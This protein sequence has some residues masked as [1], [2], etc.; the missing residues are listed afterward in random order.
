MRIKEKLVGGEVKRRHGS[1][2]TLIELLVVIA[3]IAILASMLLPALN[4]ARA[5]AKQ[6]SCANNQKQIG[7]YMQF[8]LD[9]YK[10]FFPKH[11]FA[12]APH[13]W[14]Q[15]LAYIYMGYGQFWAMKDIGKTFKCESVIE[16]LAGWENNDWVHTKDLSYGYNYTHLGYDCRLSLVKKPS[17][18]VTITDLEVRPS[19][20]YIIYPPLVKPMI[21]TGYTN[22]WGVANW[23]NDGTN[24][25]FVDGHVKWMKEQDLYNHPEW[26]YVK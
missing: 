5:K 19:G 16:P 21:G 20:Y 7:N 14:A 22:N 8:Y 4:Q 18:T 15:K 10:E 12:S 23:H 3:I 25:L 13:I 11:Y 6:A 2:F 17:T 26:F 9:D 24:V 1:T